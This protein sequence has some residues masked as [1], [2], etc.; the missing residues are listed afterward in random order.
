MTLGPG[1]GPHPPEPSPKT[2]ARRVCV[3][4]P[5]TRFLSGITY[6]TFGLIGALA[7]EQRV[8]A[9]L[10]RRLLPARLYPGRARVGADLSELKLPSEVAFA[11]GIDWYW[12]TGLGKVVRLM[13][14][15]RPEVVVLQW[16][17]GAVLH[18]YLLLAV[19]A[20]AMGA[21]VV[22]EF[23]EALDTGEERLGWVRH[24]VGNL[25]PVLFWLTSRFVVHTEHD[26][27]LVVER[28]RLDARRTV[29]IPHAAYDHHKVVPV[30]SEDGRCRLLYFGVVRPF[31]GV[32]DLIAA[33]DILT[34]TGNQ[35]FRLTI[36]GETW[37][38]WNVPE[39]MIAASPARDQ[40]RRLDRYVTDAEAG[41]AFAAA[42]VV[43]LPYRR[44]SSSG[45][46]HIAMAMGLPVVTTAVGGL[47]EATAAY[48]GAVIAEPA[49]P[50]SLAR[51]ILAASE[52]RG[53]RFSG[54]PSWA[55]T[56]AAYGVLIDH[57]TARKGP[58]V[59]KRAG[60]SS[61]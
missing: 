6:Y 42:D 8:S 55:D 48:S 20:H 29:L 18:T 24:Y 47:P 59:R 3:V 22:V 61:R 12:G 2:A 38:N 5:G 23:H 32:D 50:E 21:S 40:I 16:W 60:A 25:A 45:P 56:A 1:G 30:P 10:F 27:R 33:F 15:E 35:G 51:A 54:A 4:G 41:A 58:A 43:V 11:D 46:L 7:H 26:R 53:Q 34:A 17:T 37:E 49:A 44:C 36:V 52:L 39:K 9:I 19:M 31:K 14:R 28:Y 13:R 57:L